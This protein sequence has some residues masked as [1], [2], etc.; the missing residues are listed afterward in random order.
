[1][2]TGTSLLGVGRE[3]IKRRAPGLPRADRH[4]ARA[5]IRSLEISNRQPQPG[6]TVHLLSR[7]VGARVTERR[8]KHL[9]TTS[10]LINLHGRTALQIRQTEPQRGQAA[11]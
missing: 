9:Q 3:H 4:A 8:K 2:D 11:S 7:P 6:G 10:Y 1:M 5:R